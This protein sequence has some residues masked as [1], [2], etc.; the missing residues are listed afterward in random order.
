MP[1]RREV[2]VRPIIP[3]PKYDSKLV[4]KFMKS[5]M[6][7]GKKS[8]AEKIMYDAFDIIQEKNRGISF[9]DV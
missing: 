4:A 6:R 2:P 1:R 9:K 5:I 7:D 3:D 8:V